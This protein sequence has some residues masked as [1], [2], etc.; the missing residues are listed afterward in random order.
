[1]VDI[2][3]KNFAVHREGLKRVGRVLY[4]V[5]IFNIANRSALFVIDCMPLGNTFR[6]CLLLR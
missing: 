4:G 5:D 1:M 6:Q 3:T 2:L